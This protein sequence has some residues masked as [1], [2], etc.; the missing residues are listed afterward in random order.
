MACLC[1]PLCVPSTELSTDIWHSPSP[2]LLVLYQQKGLSIPTKMIVML[3]TCSTLPWTKQIYSFWILIKYLTAL[4]DESFHFLVTCPKISA[5]PSNPERKIY[6]QTKKH[7]N[8]STGIEVLG[9]IWAN[10]LSDLGNTIRNLPFPQPRPMIQQG[11]WSQI[12]FSWH[13]R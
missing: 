6:Q 12:P 13:W 1:L 10:V 9:S 5:D 7:G 4:L 2:N 11:R 3:G 8:Q